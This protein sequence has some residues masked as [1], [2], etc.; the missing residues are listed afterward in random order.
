MDI[1]FKIIYLSSAVMIHGFGFPNLQGQFHENKFLGFMF[2]EQKRE[3]QEFV[4]ETYE[5]IV[6]TYVEC[7][8]RLTQLAIFI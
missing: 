6:G 2:T 1:F 8:E 5:Y 7:K 4:P 3:T